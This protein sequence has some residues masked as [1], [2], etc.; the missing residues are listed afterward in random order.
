ME[1]NLPEPKGASGVSD[2]PQSW[3]PLCLALLNLIPHG[4]TLGITLLFDYDAS[5]AAPTFGCVQRRVITF[6]A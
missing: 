6:S 3:M 1:N 5:S 4:L 2:V